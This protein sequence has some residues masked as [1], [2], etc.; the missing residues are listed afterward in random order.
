MRNKETQ[1]PKMS[2]KKIDPVQR[3]E[4]K[5]MTRKKKKR[6]E[7]MEAKQERV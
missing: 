6:G 1:I 5:R 4:T 7:G 2:R 3:R